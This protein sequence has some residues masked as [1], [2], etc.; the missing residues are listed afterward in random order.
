MNSKTKLVFHKLNLAQIASLTD[1]LVYFIDDSI[2]NDIFG[3]FLNEITDGFIE[4]I[5]NSSKFLK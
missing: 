4:R 3:N 1:V 5:K 2:K